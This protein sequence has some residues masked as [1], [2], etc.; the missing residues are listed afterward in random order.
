MLQKGEM[1]VLVSSHN[2]R[3]LEDVCDCVGIMHKG[4]IYVE[5]NLDHLKSNVHKI[6]I[7]VQK[8]LEDD[9]LHK[10]NVLHYKKMGS[11]Y[12]IISRGDK[13]KIVNELK[14]YDPLIVDILP[15]TLE[16]VFIYEMRGAGYGIQDIIL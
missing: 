5:K 10:E 16:E 12:M 14:R 9:F 6:Q 1:S 2:L 7:A 15:L 3:E 8:D 13:E 11:V 4:K